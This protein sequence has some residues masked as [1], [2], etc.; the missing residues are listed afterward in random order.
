MGPLC[1]LVCANTDEPS[2]MLYR[3]QETSITLDEYVALVSY[4]KRHERPSAIRA[5]LDALARLYPDHER[6]MR[7]LL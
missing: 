7:G 2:N 6:S 5:K 4:I 3:K 1:L